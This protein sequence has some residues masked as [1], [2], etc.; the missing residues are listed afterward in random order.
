MMSSRLEKKDWNDPMLTGR[1]RVLTH[2]P[3]GAYPNAAM[4]RGC[5]RTASPFVR[6]LN[7]TWKFALTPSPET[8]PDGFDRTDADD[9]AWLDMAVPSNWQLDPRVADKPIYTNVP[10]P[11]RKTPPEPPAVNPTGWYRTSFEVPA[12]WDG[13]QVFL[14]FESCDSACKIWVNG[15]EAGYSEDSKLPH[16]FNVTD[17]VHPGRN[18]LAVMV[19]RY[20][21]GFF[22]ECQDY[23]HLSGI[24][25]DVVL[26]SKPRAH[27][28]D[29]T[30]RTTFDR[31]YRDAELGVNAYMNE[32]EDMP[33][34]YTFEIMLYDANGKPVMARP[35]A[36]PVQLSSPMG[37]DTRHEYTA[38][39]FRV[40][41][42]QPQAW[43]DETPYLYTLV[44]TLKDPAGKAVDFESSRVGFRQI[45]IRD[46]QLLLNGRRLIVRGV[47]CHEHHPEK[48]R[49]MSV[50]D[51]RQELV[52]MKQLN[53][54][55]VRTSHYPHATAFYDLCDEL[56]MCVIDEANL[57]THGIQA[58]T[59]KDPVWMN[60]YMERAQRMALRDRNHPSVIGWSLGNE[61]FYGAHHAGMAGWL[62]Q[63][64]PTRPV[65]YESGNPGRNITDILCPMYP[66]LDWVV[67]VLADAKETRPMIMCE[68]AYAKGNA[69]GNVKKFWDMVDRWPSF[70]G[71]CV[72]DWRDKALVRVV[73]G[74]KEWA[75][76]N[77]FDG[78]IGP[79]GFNYG[80]DENPQM[81]LN[82]VVNPDLTPKPGA[83]E[84]KKVQA[85]VGLASDGGQG[86]MAGAVTVWNKY[87]AL[88]LSHLEFAWEF[89]EDGAVLQS[90]TLKAPAAQ[91][92]TKAALKVPFTAPARLKAG[93][94]YW[95]NV[96]ARL[97]KSAPWA[98][99]GHAIAW[100]QFRVPFKAPGKPAAIAG[101]PLAWKASRGVFA[102]GGKRFA[103]TFDRR[104][105]ALTGYR[106]DG[107][108]LI[109][110]PLEHSFLR[111]RTDN[112][113]ILGN[114]SS[115]YAEWRAAG[116]DR[117]ETEVIE[118]VGARLSDASAIV[119]CRTRHRAQ[120]RDAGFIC[121]TAYTIR[122]TGEVHVSNTVQID[123]ALPILP[124]IGMKLGVAPDLEALCWYGRGPH[125]NYVDRK[126]SAPVGIY[127]STVEDQFFP[128]VDPCECGGHEDT[129]WLTLCDRRGRGLKITGEP[130]LHFS[131]LHYT[132]DD[133]IRAGHV[134]ELHRT[135]DVQLNLDGFHMGLGGDTG[136]TRNV[137]PEYLLSPGTYRYGFRFMPVRHTT[138]QR[139]EGQQ[140]RTWKIDFAS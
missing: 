11:F 73:N 124:R 9:S 51:I 42:K 24:Q 3:M 45:E 35:E 109:T 101:Q 90:G 131:A 107:R 104:L 19:P 8:M 91:P 10:Y 85:P 114:P 74:K 55:T 113:Y 81:C 38:S 105:G 70:Q 120:D 47:D 13:R 63:Y 129:R 97:K 34:G 119:R 56:G 76:G 48:G 127:Q 12:A 26:Y 93:G 139:R 106:L 61:S 50:S 75:Y 29:F 137:H 6:S 116:L 59:S 15:V 126:E 39:S 100:E 54:N 117:L 49:A 122:S 31:H 33:Q 69:N 72:W 82:G 65:Q 44:L 79:D 58:L 57:E 132:I 17:L 30:V 20:C 25:R 125:E 110:R 23:W 4:A 41:V 52:A 94:E 115:Y 78:G 118:C 130:A 43:T 27:I 14:L 89:T 99:R 98:K 123:A 86:L 46:R 121:D 67:Q 80:K 112:D 5:D 1:N 68:Y 16:E 138:V 40:P 37:G 92:G 77:E 111:A 32:T 7:G 21:S 88:D 36:A 102:A 18:H 22:L 28:R 136:W 135:D 84:L 64:D 62:R 134:Y 66:W 108:D 103:V 60:A 83:L 140:G 87:L 128:F 53:F 71:G 2:V 96:T 95:L 133:L